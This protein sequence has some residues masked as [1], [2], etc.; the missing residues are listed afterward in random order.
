MP[1]NEGS[2]SL[3]RP[4]ANGHRSTLGAA[5][6]GARILLVEDLD[7]LGADAADTRRRAQ[8]LEAAGGRVTWIAVVGSGWISAEP[9]AAGEVVSCAEAP[10]RLEALCKTPWDQV[11]LASAARGGGALTRFLPAST[12]WWPTGWAA[13][14]EATGWRRFAAR[15]WGERRLATPDGA[16]AWSAHWPL[17]W[18]EVDPIGT[19]RPGLPLWDGDLML[20]LDGLAQRHGRVTIEAFARIAD[21][22]TG[23]DLVGLSEPTPALQE[24]S[25]AAGVEMRVHHVGRPPRLAESSWLAQAS[26]ALLSDGPRL[27][28][29]LV[30]RVLAAGC[31]LLWVAPSVGSRALARWL[32]EHGGAQI[33]A[34]QPKAIASALEALLERGPEVE[35]A[36]ERGRA[37]AARHDRRALLERL[38]GSVSAP[39]SRRRAA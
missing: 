22:W 5:Q 38:A 39:E 10:S 1:R 4:H 13:A 35:A 26:V 14:R 12:Y 3:P 6:A 18:S 33:V 9:D 27:S 2:A 11:V 17:G 29:G 37:L 16:S 31:P 30:L 20:S 23:V 24:R 28:A 32:E 25:R 21:T 7:A 8:R 36:I 19:R 15:A 34:G